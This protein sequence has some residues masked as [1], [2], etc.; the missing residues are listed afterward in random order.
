MTD[1]SR[2]KLGTSK[3][4]FCLYRYRTSEPGMISRGE[5]CE[6]KLRPSAVVHARKYEAD[7]PPS[8]TVP[9]VQIEGIFMRV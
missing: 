2:W 4:I 7:K 8:F 3:V 1:S 6:Q 5:D 9:Q